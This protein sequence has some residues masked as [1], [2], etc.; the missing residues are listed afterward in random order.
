MHDAGS[1]A[2]IDMHEN[3]RD[4]FGLMITFLS[5]N[6][7]PGQAGTVS[8]TV[9]LVC[10]LSC[11][12]SRHAFRGCT[13]RCEIRWSFFHATACAMTHFLEIM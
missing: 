7:P 6:C 10:T 11:R 8:L 9:T 3:L 4:G 12:T 2:A 1:Y 5:E 13:S